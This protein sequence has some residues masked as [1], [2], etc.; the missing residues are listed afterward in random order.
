M[1]RELVLS[2]L[3]AAV[4]LLPVHDRAR[5]AQAADAPVSLSIASDQP[6]YRAGQPII[7][8]ITLRNESTN[9]SAIFVHHV[10]HRD[11]RLT[12]TSQGKTS[13]QNLPFVGET[14]F[15]RDM[16]AVGQ[17]LSESEPLSA[18]RYKLGSGTFT[19]SARY[20]YDV[21]GAPLTSN[22]I[23]VTVTP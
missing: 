7:L 21:G 6:T 12:V 2:V 17:T 16:L 3:A 18:W 20:F 19:I 23:T 4:V 13:H 10:A 15:L 14:G 11:V 1:T 22:S 5:I 9:S 8:T